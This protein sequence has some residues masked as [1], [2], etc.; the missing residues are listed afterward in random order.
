[1]ESGYF[2]EIV[3]RRY[4][5]SR[6]YCSLFLRVSWIAFLSLDFALPFE[7]FFGSSP[8][9]FSEGPTGSCYFELVLFQVIARALAVALTY[10]EAPGPSATEGRW[11]TRGDWRSSWFAERQVCELLVSLC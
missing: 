1:M 11:L 4:R 10:E 5:A 9:K 3:A 2:V 7:G 8:C 6:R